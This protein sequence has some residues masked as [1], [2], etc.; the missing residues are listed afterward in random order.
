MGY[1]YTWNPTSGNNFDVLVNWDTTA[2]NPPTIGT[3]GPVYDY[4]S[5]VIFT[6]A[7]DSS[8]DDDVTGGGSA[9]FFQVYGSQSFSGA[10]TADGQVSIGT[11]PNLTAF[12]VT[13]G[14][15]TFSGAL[16]A[17]VANL[18][19]NADVLVGYGDPNGAAPASLVFSGGATATL[20]TGNVTDFTTGLRIA[21]ESLY[22]GD[23]HNGSVVIKGAGT[24]V[25]TD[26][27]V[28]LGV[29]A[30]VSGSLTVQNDGALTIG[31]YDLGF[32]F[33]VGY[34][35]DGTLTVETGGKVMAE[36]AIDIGT[37]YGSTGA[38]VVDGKGSDLHAV[39]AIFVG[40]ASTDPSRAADGIGSLTVSNGA[41]VETDSSIHVFAGSTLTVES[42]GSVTSTGLSG[43]GA[44][45]DVESGATVDISGAGSTISATGTNA[46]PS[47]EGIQVAAGG[48]IT[49]VGSII[50]T[51]VQNDGT[52][53]A[54]SFGGAGTLVVDS[55]TTAIA[56]PGTPGILGISGD[57]TL[58]LEGG[59]AADET[60]VFNNTAGASYHETLKID[61][62]PSSF[63][64]PI[65]GLQAGDAIDLTG[66]SGA[67]T[68]SLDSATDI[69][70]VESAS[71]T[72]LAALQL[73]G[74]YA[75]VAFSQ[76]SDGAGGLTLT[77]SAA[78]E[79]P[80]ITSGSGRSATYV[81]NEGFTAITDIQASGTDVQYFLKD[82]KTG[83]LVS[84]TS[85]FSINSQTGALN[86]N[87]PHDVG[88]FNVTV[89]AKDAAGQTSQSVNV[90]ATGHI[91]FGDFGESDT[92]VFHAGFG[93]DY[94]FGFQARST[95]GCFASPHDV[96][97]LDHSM[98]TGAT[99][100][101]TG[102]ALIALLQG[103]AHQTFAGTEINTNT[104]DH[105]L[106]LGVS[107]QA[108]LANAVADVHM[109]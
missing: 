46:D 36:G 69:L 103:D 105:L 3:D 75:A 100:G 4:D 47:L 51:I 71:G 87:S 21:E 76:A 104:G 14:T 16:T 50:G 45:V 62:S 20:D 85:L 49:G 41:T 91:M 92:F 42:G 89:V 53:D 102:S 61:G 95:N 66:L 19:T 93:T 48:L 28:A 54:S 77:E 107:K 97:Q 37:L 94:L 80:T 34:S 90:D 55:L 96:L 27:G 39:Q 70:T 106:L 84:S 68:W 26:S 11:Q 24:A 25:T 32:G 22:V 58:E 10:Y 43:V 81:I 31:S 72:T 64:A 108:L 33:D 59:V 73:I 35:G 82:P 74:D 29:D 13:G 30:G 5:T 40:T 78:A 88:D 99:Q 101:E 52:I 12:Q 17:G 83:H 23:D 15:A 98:F 79:A 1:D 60:V 56:D 6:G 86:L 38:V 67:T 44:R 8:G 2:P 65:S 18:T 109:V 7:L 63:D 57:A 9:N